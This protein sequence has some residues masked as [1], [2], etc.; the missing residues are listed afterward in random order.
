MQLASPSSSNVTSAIA[1]GK[2]PC[3][4]STPSVCHLAMGRS[5]SHACV[6]L[7]NFYRNSL[8][9]YAELCTRLTL[10]AYGERHRPICAGES[11]A[12]PARAGASGASHGVAGLKCHLSR[13]AEVILMRPA[14]A[15]SG[16]TDESYMGGGANI[17]L[18]GNGCAKWVCQPRRHASTG[19]PMAI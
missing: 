18:P 4:T 11:G 15:V 3:S 19:R 12:A 16:A 1:A 6:T 5:E 7:C 17:T 2:S 10:A 14:C 9:K 13:H 8:R